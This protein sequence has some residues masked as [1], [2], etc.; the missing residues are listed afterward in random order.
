MAAKPKA[1][2]QTLT[3]IMQLQ[4]KVGVKPDGDFG[5]ATLK[6]CRD[7]FKMTNNQAAHFFGQC[8]HET[9]GFKIFSENLNYSSEGLLRVFRKYFPT[10]AVAAKYANK[11]QAIANKVYGGRM[12]NGPESSNDGWNYRGRGA[13][14]LTGRN[15]YTAFARHINRP[16]V[17][18]NPAIVAGE[19]AFE[20][21]L[22][23]FQRNNL[24]AICNQGVSVATITAL[25]RRV[26][27][28]THGLSDRIA[29]TQQYAMWL[30]T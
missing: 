1:K 28:G 20:S 24:F 12:G 14:Q 2:P 29:K 5:P 21:A 30:L 6:A 17:M 16:D 23:F 11:P 8:A 18:T 19:L 13:I 4:K 7:Y 27:G 9:G 22:F 10:A 15:N 26:N 25:T 3:P